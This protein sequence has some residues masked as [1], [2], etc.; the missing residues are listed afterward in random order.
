MNFAARRAVV[1]MLLLGCGLLAMPADAV[2]QSPSDE[3]THPFLFGV[4]Y[5][6][7]LKWSAVIGASLPAT[8]RLRN[9]F[10]AAE[11]GIGGW[12]ASV[13]YLKLQ[14]DLGAGYAVRGTFLRTNDRAWRVT[15]RTAFVGAE[16]QV[17]PLFAFGARLGGF[18][19][20]SGEGDRRA[21]LTADL[22][23]ML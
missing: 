14:S 12:R 7:P 5:G 3:S 9:T 10:V 23:V 21:I 16:L 13:G 22:S 4:H 2:A 17:M 19:R 20:V 15:P 8:G 11:P 6:L 18:V 1:R